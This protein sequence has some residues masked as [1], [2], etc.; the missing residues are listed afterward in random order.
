MVATESEDTMPKQIMNLAEMD[1]NKRGKVF[2]VNAG[3]RATQRL[4]GLGI[5]PG[6]I[7]EKISQAPFRGPIQVKV[8]GS[9]LAL[10]RGLA[11]KIMVEVQ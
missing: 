1:Q 5:T 11:L 8:R 9:R 2:R 3:R 10:G 4:S 7:I 6:T